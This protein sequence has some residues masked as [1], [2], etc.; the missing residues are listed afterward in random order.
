MGDI[1]SSKENL[2][3]EERI[4]EINGFIQKWLLDQ[5]LVF[6]QTEGYEFEQNG[7]LYTI[8]IEDVESIRLRHYQNPDLQVIGP[9]R[10]LLSAL[11]G[12][13]E[14]LGLI[15]SAKLLVDDQIHHFG[16]LA[17]IEIEGNNHEVLLDVARRRPVPEVVP[18]NGEVVIS[19]FY[20]DMDFISY[21]AL[22]EDG[23]IHFFVVERRLDGSGRAKN[24]T[25]RPLTSVQDEREKVL[26]AIRFHHEV[27]R[28]K[29]D[30]TG[31]FLRENR[32]N[33]PQGKIRMEIR[34]ILL[35]GGDVDLEIFYYQ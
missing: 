7:D 20:D 11:H 14:A 10:F 21:K 32:I 2:R 29:F 1:E 24:I 30:K 25:Y 34:K 16:L 8:R 13:L 27:T 6:D 12:K 9:C 22:E 19:S 4:S 35:E 33:T 23:L 5:T 18:L 31:V 26:E 3:L 28:A 17:N 15:N